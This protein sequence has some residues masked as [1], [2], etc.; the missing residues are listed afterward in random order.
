[1]K[2]L[3]PVYQPFLGDKEKEYVNDCLDSSWISSKGKYIEMFEKEF[4]KQTRVKYATSVCN[5][6]VAI[7][8]ALLSLGIGPDDEVIVPTFTYI[9]SVN[10]IQYTGA[11]PVF[12]DSNLET[13]QIDTEDVK[14]KITKKTKA[15][16][17]VHLYG[18]SCDMDKLKKIAQENK[19]F[20][21]EDCAEAF[22]TTFKG[23]HVGSFGDI[24][25]YSFFGN[26]TI[27]TGEGGMVVSN[28]ETLYER[29][30][31]LKEQ[32]LAK[33]RQYWHD[34]V[35]YNYRLS[36]IACAIGLAQ[37]EKSEKILNKKRQIANYYKKVFEGTDYTLHK[38][39]ENTYHSYWMCSILVNENKF[40]KNTR[41]ELREHLYSKKIETRPLFYPVHTMPMYY[42]NYQ[43]LKNAE[44]ISRRGINLPS[45]PDLKES[46]LKY[47]CDSVLEF[48]L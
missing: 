32:G 5:G 23:Q 36:N 2:Y 22:G 30:K 45:Y 17:A 9:A 42:T 43:T 29:T 3:I 47:I 21:I 12:V 28:N 19:I 46:E 34:V 33:Y 27:T 48:N 41:D 14:Q 10:A 40:N 13:W 39:A 20:L 6:T 16:L 31:H 11:K 4:A 25:T 15:I 8:V 18:Q 35:G 37:L 44:N 7:H 26:K 24:S 38:E 1:M